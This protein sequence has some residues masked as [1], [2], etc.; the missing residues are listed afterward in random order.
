MAGFPDE[1]GWNGDRGPRR[2]PGAFADGDKKLLLERLLFGSPFV[3]PDGTEMALGRS[4][5]VV[6]PTAA[7][8]CFFVSI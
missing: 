1:R 8:Q 7:A 6:A 5:A 3:R 4:L 2:P